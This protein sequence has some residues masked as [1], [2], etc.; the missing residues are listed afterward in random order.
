VDFLRKGA[1]KIFAK[2]IG[3]K[4]L[5][6]MK[7]FSKGESGMTIGK[8]IASLRAEKDVS[9]VKL[10]EDIGV[11]RSLLYKWE[12]DSVIPSNKSV[13]KL[14]EYFGVPYSY[15]YGEST[16][17]AP[18]ATAKE[19]EQSDLSAKKDETDNTVAELKQI[20]D[21]YAKEN[22][23]SEM[24]IKNFLEKVFKEDFLLRKRIVVLILSVLSAISVVSTVYLG[25]TIFPLEEDCAK[26]A[27]VPVLV[28]V[29]ICAI[30]LSLGFV[31][32]AICVKVLWK[33]K[34]LL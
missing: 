33:W 18:T 17:N 2:A 27:D 4:L 31:I 6:G 28:L 13:Q 14:S 15:F 9:Q 32:A 16:E 25:V 34:S 30:I 26:I 23:L 8:K 1:G 12:S 20:I 22:D 5:S 3:Y 7:L 29:F 10:A 21:G 19:D 24:G 11:S